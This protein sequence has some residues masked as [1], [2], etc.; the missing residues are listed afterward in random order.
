[1]VSAATAARLTAF[2]SAFSGEVRMLARSGFVKTSNM[3]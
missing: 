3:R 2:H 1:M